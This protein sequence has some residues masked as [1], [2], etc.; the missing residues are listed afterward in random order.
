ML[1]RYESNNPSYTCKGSLLARF[2]GVDKEL[3]GIHTFICLRCEKLHV[4][5]IDLKKIN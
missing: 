2:K 4:F 3:T 1:L 5:N